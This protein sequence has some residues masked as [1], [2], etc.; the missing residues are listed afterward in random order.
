MCWGYFRNYERI[1]VYI[2]GIWGIKIVNE[3][4]DYFFFKMDI[5][6]KKLLK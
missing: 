1:V 2:L 6:N 3:I 4:N 5:K